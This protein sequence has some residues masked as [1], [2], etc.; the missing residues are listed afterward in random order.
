MEAG[1]QQQSAVVAKSPSHSWGETLRR[2]SHVS[3]NLRPLGS[4]V[5]E[6]FLQPTGLC[7]PPLRPLLLSLLFIVLLFFHTFDKVGGASQD[8]KSSQALAVKLTGEAGGQ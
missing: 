6:S 1:A 2:R 8:A 4:N 7:L 5:S 3:E